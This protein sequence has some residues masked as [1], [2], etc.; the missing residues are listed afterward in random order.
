[1]TT[2]TLAQ[3][4]KALASVKARFPDAPGLPEGYRFD[5]RYTRAE[6]MALWYEDPGLFMVI[7]RAAALALCVTTA[8]EIGA[9]WECGSLGTRSARLGKAHAYD[10]W[11]CLLYDAIMDQN[12][13]T[14][15]DS[16]PRAAL[17]MLEVIGGENGTA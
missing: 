6:P 2:P 3:F 17:A 11:A 7:P 8:M 14:Y 9:W 5:G 4:A 16:L 10:K 12:E 15:H 13:T 1:M